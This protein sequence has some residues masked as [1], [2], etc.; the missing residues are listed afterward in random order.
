VLLTG[1]DTAGQHVADYALTIS[2][3]E[4]QRYRMMAARAVATER[5][6]FDLAGVAPGARIADIGCGPA[7]LSVA[8]AGI[9]G[10]SGSV[11]GVERD[12]ASL[13]TARQLVAEAPVTNV[14]LRAGEAD[15]TGL[16]ADSFDV[17]LMRHVLAHNG[18]H[19]QSIV[20]HLTTLVRPG[21]CVYLVDVDLTAIR[22]RGMD[23]DL[24]DLTVRY[25]EFHRARGND[26]CIGLRLDE[27]VTS[28]GLELVHYSG[29][30]DILPVPPGVRPPSWAAREAM[31]AQGTVS[32]ADVARW[33]AAF[34][35]RD[36]A[37]API[38][39]FFPVFIAI[40]RRAA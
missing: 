24:A 40:G 7:A 32:T 31:L 28:A 14:E 18:G 30:F 22:F 12:A 19:E 5:E 35:R 23:E 21:G 34:D 8:V 33:G 25:A 38:T 16:D 13:E 10:G 26:P 15:A 37:A 1:S 29:R 20:D 3:V 2:D 27:L 9:V 39:G 36:A 6:L 11:V 4:V 17:V